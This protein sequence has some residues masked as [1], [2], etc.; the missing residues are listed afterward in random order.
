[1]TP[2]EAI[3]SDKAEARDPVEALAEEFL[4]RYRTGERPPLTEYVRRHP[5][6]A[7]EIRELFP[8]LVMME[9]AAPRQSAGPAAAP[10]RAGNGRELH[11]LGDFRVLREVGRGGM[12]IVYEAEQ[13]SLGRRVALK[14]LPF[15]AAS[16]PSRLER[17]RREARSA[18]RLHHSHIVPVYEVGEHQGVY[19]YAMQFIP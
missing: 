5:E 10:P 3:M 9:E 8:A 16:D 13:E 7:D 1:M 14:V 2:T 18:A 11:R 12:G 19:Y 4:E 17:F 6:L 15:Q